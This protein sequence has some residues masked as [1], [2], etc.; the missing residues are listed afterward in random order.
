MQFRTR[1]YLPHLEA[2]DSTYF[3]TFRLSG[4]LPQNVLREIVEE[5]KVLSRT[6]E[7]SELNKE[8]LARQKYLQTRAVQQYLDKGIGECWLSNSSVAEMVSNAFHF[9]EGSRY[10]QHAFCIMPNH[11]HWLFTPNEGF[12]LP[13]I[14]HSLKSFTANEANKL[15][16]R[17]GTF[18]NKEY[19]D[20]LVRDSEQ[21]GKIVIYV[22]EN[23]V[24]AGLCKEWRDWRWSWCSE[25][26][27]DALS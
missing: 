11:V 10:Q 7:K 26:I 4:T 25:N 14:L 3:V 9:F 17:R 1:G 27:R 18:W 19:Y 22:L 2:T 20:H 16:N 5:S 12:S 8:Q 13:Q 24:N 6:R 21:F 15:L 23:P